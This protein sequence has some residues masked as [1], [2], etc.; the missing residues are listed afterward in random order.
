MKVV[1]HARFD[2]VE[3]RNVLIA[4]LEPA[5]GGLVFFLAKSHDLMRPL[6]FGNF[7]VWARPNHTSIH[8]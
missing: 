3:L 7:S 6:L 8:Q 5:Y 4:L 2:V 1:N